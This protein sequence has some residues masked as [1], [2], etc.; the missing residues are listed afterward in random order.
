[1]FLKNSVGRIIEKTVGGQPLDDASGEIVRA[2]FRSSVF[3]NDVVLKNVADPD[4]LFL[5]NF[6]K[7]KNKSAKDIT[8]KSTRNNYRSNKNRGRNQSR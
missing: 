7:L 3:N 1:M 4:N 5:A 2:V 8:A 6:N